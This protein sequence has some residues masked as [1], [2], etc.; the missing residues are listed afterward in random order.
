MIQA[1]PSLSACDSEGCHSVISSLHQVSPL[2]LWLYHTVSL[3][4]CACVSKYLRRSWFL[5]RFVCVCVHHADSFIHFKVWG[6]HLHM[7]ICINMCIY[8]YIYIHTYVYTHMIWVDIV[9]RNSLFQESSRLQEENKKHAASWRPASGMVKQGLGHALKLSSSVVRSTRAK[10][11]E[12]PW[13]LITC[14][15][16]CT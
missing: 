10:T 6:V 4:V 12:R 8:I 14:A 3:R 15:G 9:I 1:L 16:L 11:Q 2:D 13:V 7:Y 5:W